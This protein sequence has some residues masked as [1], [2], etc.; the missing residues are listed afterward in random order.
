MQRSSYTDYRTPPH[1][2]QPGVGELETRLKARPAAYAIEYAYL[3]AGE[4]EDAH[5]NFEHLLHKWAPATKEAFAD[6]RVLD[7]LPAGGPTGVFEFDRLMGPIGH[8][9]LA[10]RRGLDIRTIHLNVPAAFQHMV[11]QATTANPLITVATVRADVVAHKLVWAIGGQTVED[12]SEANERIIDRCL[13]A[14]AAAGAS[15]SDVA[16][17]YPTLCR[18]TLVSLDIAEV[19]QPRRF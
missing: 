15:I 12:T 13:E 1:L 17:C 16:P 4:T 6:A 11:A 8:L 9:F 18:R 19:L 3:K 10:R 14:L 7:G 5:L 2:L